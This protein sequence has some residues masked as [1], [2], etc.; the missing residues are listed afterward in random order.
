[1]PKPVEEMRQKLHE[2]VEKGK[3][4]EATEEVGKY[5]GFSKFPVEGKSHYA[6][7]F[8]VETVGRY[9]VYHQIKDTMSVGLKRIGKLETIAKKDVP[10]A[11]RLIELMVGHEGGHTFT[12][13]SPVLIKGKKVPYSSDDIMRAQ[14]R[15][16]M[17]VDGNEARCQ[18]DSQAEMYAA[19]MYRAGRTLGEL[20]DAMSENI[21]Y[22]FT[23]Y[24]QLVDE[25]G[26]K[27]A[28]T[29]T[30]QTYGHRYATACC[31]WLKPKIIDK[32]IDNAVKIDEM[33]RQ[34]PRDSKI[35]KIL[36]FFKF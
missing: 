31:P 30:V 5:H 6:Y 20:M 36:N 2:L 8:T 9:G 25:L 10:L 16:G 7:T 17:Y 18:R 23:T 27:D 1:M 19:V 3:V 26:I 33:S 29:E 22:G 24:T 11:E 32:I 35:K 4:F 34:K 21:W 14:F 28:P 12:P 15:R 13:K